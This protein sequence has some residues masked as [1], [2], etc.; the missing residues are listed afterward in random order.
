MIQIKLDLK[1]G[2][3]SYQNKNKNIYNL[4]VIL[5]SCFIHYHQTTL[6]KTLKRLNYSICTLLSVCTNTSKT[7]NTTVSTHFTEAIFNLRK[8]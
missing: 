6:R 4:L 2:E 5:S 7:Y 8:K 3:S 1:H